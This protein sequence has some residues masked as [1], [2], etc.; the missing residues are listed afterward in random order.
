MD[1]KNSF[2]NGF[3]KE[4]VF[5]EQPERFKDSTNPEFVCKLKRGLYGLKQSPRIWFERLAN[6]LKVVSFKQSLAYASVFVMNAKED[7]AI[8]MLYVDD[9]IMTSNNDDSICE[10]KKKLSTQFEMK[11]LGELKYFLGIEV[12]K[13]PNGLMLLQRKYMLDMLRQL[14][15]KIVSQYKHQW[16]QM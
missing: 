4:E 7:I 16:N 10:I 1:V 15:C 8:I 6:Y 12:V 2:L 3:L 11:D 5:I 9:L 14:V 13:C